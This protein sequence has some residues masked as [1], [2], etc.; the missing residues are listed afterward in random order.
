MDLF[1]LEPAVQVGKPKMSYIAVIVA[2]SVN[3][4][5]GAIWFAVFATPWLVGIGKSRADLMHRGSPAL[6]YL[7]VF[8]SN[9]ALAWALAWLIAVTGRPTMARG[10]GLAALLWLGFVG[11][12]MAT[13]HVFEG[14][15][16]QSLAITA[17]Y[18]L[19]GMLIMGAILGHWTGRSASK[20]S[21]DPRK[22]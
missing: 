17:G 15:S 9:L 22:P 5:L 4:V 11:S 1:P 13:E 2:A 12:T 3:W 21:Q 6:D 14:R 18:P 16:I 10:V 20:P 7:L 19:A 8:V